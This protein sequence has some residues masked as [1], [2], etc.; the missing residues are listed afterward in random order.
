MVLAG[1]TEWFGVLMNRYLPTVRRRISSIVP[2]T[3]DVEDLAQDVFVKIWR[4]LST[5]REESAFRTWVIR[6]AINEAVNSCRR[7][8]RRPNYQNLADMDTFASPSES[9]LQSLVRAE[10]NR[11]LHKAVK[12][13]PDGYKQILVLREFDQLSIQEIAQSARLT[14]PTV[15]TRLFRGRLKLLSLLQETRSPGWGVQR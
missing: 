5:F 3:A 7:K 12:K 10:A 2:G 6:I 13:L 15:K 4:H 14:V 11:A 1:E 8:Q 9:P